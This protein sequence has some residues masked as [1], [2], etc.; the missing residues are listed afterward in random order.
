M[1]LTCSISGDH[2]FEAGGCSESA[3]SEILCGPAALATGGGG[4]PLGGSVMLAVARTG[5]GGK[6][7]PAMA[8]SRRRLLR[9][10]FDSDAEGERHRKRAL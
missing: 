3:V 7:I 9:G 10:T 5:L 4:G 8:V 2:L 1:P 6:V